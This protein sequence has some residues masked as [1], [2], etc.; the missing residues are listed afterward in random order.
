MR[1]AFEVTPALEKPPLVCAS[2]REPFVSTAAGLQRTTGGLVTALDG[3]LRRLGGTWVA[4]SGEATVVDVPGEEG[5][6]YSVQ[7]LGLPGDLHEAYY[8]GFSNRVLWPL[9]HSFVDRMHFDAG[10]WHAYEE[11]NHRVATRMAQAL[12]EGGHPSPVAW[13]HD[14]H[15]LL[16]PRLV[17]TLAPQAAV[18][19]FLHIPFPAWEMFRLLPTHVEVLEGLLGAELLGFHARSYRDAFLDCCRRLPGAVVEG[20]EI[21]YEGRRTRT[22][23]APIGID[24]ARLNRVAST[25]QTRA[26][27]ARFRRRLGTK[28]VLLGVDRLDYTKGILER[29]QGFERLLK[30]HPEH[31]GHLTLVQIAVP[32]RAQIADYQALKRECDE[33]IG[34][35]NGRY[36][37]SSWTPVRYFNRNHTQEELVAWY[38][39]AD[40]ALVT[41]LRDGLNLVAK[42]YVASRLDESGALVLSEFAGAANELPSAYFV[43]PYD[44]DNIADRLHRAITD[45]REDRA[46]RMRALQQEVEGNDVQGWARRFVEEIANAHREAGT[47]H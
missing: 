33:M 4:A 34:R 18:G 14:Y 37:D 19:F 35:L 16:A 3:A 27:A 41:P 47:L 7:Q 10:Q 36:S 22:R 31:R 46:L 21:H 45:R 32:S 17:R 23:V 12:G 2:H 38:L 15:L 39:A 40:V 24:A 6:A 8:A 43:N 20:D 25:V 11:V 13:L 1:E 26:R 44:A 9:F 5:R 30:L 42:E 28:T 29:L